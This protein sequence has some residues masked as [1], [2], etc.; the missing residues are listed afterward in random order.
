MKKTFI[1]ILSLSLFSTA[2]AEIS[3]KCSYCHGSFAE[4]SALGK[5]RPIAGM[6]KKVL[7]EEMRLYKN[8]KLNKKLILKVLLMRFQN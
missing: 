3:S 7:I 8:G 6:D 1:S 4:N 5:V 2:Y